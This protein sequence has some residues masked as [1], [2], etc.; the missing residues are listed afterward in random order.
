MTSR[1]D[2]HTVWLPLAS[3]TYDERVQRPANAG[4]VARIADELDPDALGVIQVSE[5]EDGT[6]VVIDGWHRVQA[7]RKIGWQDQRVECKV[8]KGLTVQ[9]E[10]RLFT[11]LNN[12]VK[13]RYIDNF[14]VRVEAGDPDAV[15]ISQ[16]IRSAGL[17]IGRQ[18]RDGHITAVQSLER[19]YKGDGRV[20]KRANPE[21][22]R[23]LLKIVSSA[24]G[25]SSTALNGSILEG[26]GRVLLRY[27]G[28]TDINDLAKKLG[29]IHGGAAGL[30]GDA[31]AMRDIRGGSLASAVA[32]VVVSTYNKGRR[33]GKLAD[34]WSNS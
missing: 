10:A 21:A 7:L 31:R 22:V 26:V 20:T 14:F 17:A 4:R 1:K 27:N 15:A 34:W 32:G 5:R 11:E 30:L 29:P 28:K 18:S 3:L 9:E 24:W 6:L 2:G 16:L 12:T 23:D 13:P 19:V 33:S 8:R 25:S